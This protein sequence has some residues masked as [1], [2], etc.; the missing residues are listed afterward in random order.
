MP[1]KRAAP[2]RPKRAKAKK[3]LTAQA[4]LDKRKDNMKRYAAFVYTLL[5]KGYTN[6]V[7]MHCVQHGEPDQ[8]Y[9]VIRWRETQI[10]HERLRA[11]HDL[12][13]SVDG[14]LHITDGQLEIY[15]GRD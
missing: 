4:A 5:D 6:Y 12:V 2:A 13:I 1:V 3:P 10:T 8:F 9:A 15:L 7:D 14:K 11:L